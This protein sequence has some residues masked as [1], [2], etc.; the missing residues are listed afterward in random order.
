MNCKFCNEPIEKNDQDGKWYSAGTQQLHYWD[1]KSPNAPRL[2]GKKGQVQQSFQKK[3]I[4]SNEQVIETIEKRLDQIDGFLV[5]LKEAISDKVV[6]K[7]LITALMEKLK[8]VSFEKASGDSL[9]RYDRDGNM[10]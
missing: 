2:Q 10:L 7:E 8:G 5:E 4:V 9:P 1:C 6:T 3:P